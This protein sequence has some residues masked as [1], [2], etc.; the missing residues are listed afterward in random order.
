MESILQPKI[1]L[2][3]LILVVGVLFDL[4]TKKIPNKLILAGFL[5][6]ILSLVFLDGL[7]TF[8]LPAASFGS[9]VIFTLPLYMMRALGAGDVKLIFVLSFL[10][11]WKMTITMILAS[12]VWGSLLGIIRVILSGKTKEFIYNLFFILKRTE[13]E[14]N[15]LHYI[16]YSVAIFFGF[17]TSLTLDQW[18]LTW[19]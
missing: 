4:R 6:S 15:Q 10:L 5:L 1:L 3:G 14:K 16:P 9:A 12:M 2:A 8:W 19:I 11:G 13:V 18:G 17:L 7:S